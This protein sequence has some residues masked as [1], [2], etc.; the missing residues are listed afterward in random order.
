MVGRDLRHHLAVNPLPWPGT[1]S[2]RPCCS[3]C[4]QDCPE[5]HW[6]ASLPSFAQ[7]QVDDIS[8]PSLFHQQC[9]HIKEGQPDLPGTICP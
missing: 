8:C 4:H 1:P 6:K 9:N 5:Y 3:K 2:T 7:V